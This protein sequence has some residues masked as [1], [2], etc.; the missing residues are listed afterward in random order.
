MEKRTEKALLITGLVCLAAALIWAIIVSAGRVR[1]E[2]ELTTF[3]LA[4]AYLEIR[5]LSGALGKNTDA[6]LAA[7]RNAGL[8]SVIVDSSD[9]SDG[10]TAAKK[11]GLGIIYK[12][13][14]EKGGKLS[15]LPPG[16]RVLFVN[17]QIFNKESVL[18]KG[19][20]P[21]LLEL[22]KPAGYEGVPRESILTAHT[23]KDQEL[24][25]LSFFKLRDRFLRARFERRTG[26]LYLKFKC[27]GPGL[28]ENEKL[29]AELSA[30]LR[31]AGE[32]P[33]I[34]NSNPYLLGAGQHIQALK[35]T[36]FSLALFF[37]LLAF[38]AGMRYFSGPSAR[39]LAMFLISLA[40][41]IIISALLSDTVFMIKLEQFGG[42]KYALSLPVALVLIYLGF[43]NRADFTRRGL[44]VTGGL[45]LLFAVIFAVASV[46]SGNFNMPLFPFEESLRGF[47]ENIFRAR[48]R[49]KE[50]LIGYPCLLLGLH[51]LYEERFKEFRLPAVILVSV[52][53]F[54]L[55]SVVNTFCHA[56]I[57]FLLSLLRS[58]YGA[59]LGVL[60]GAILIWLSRLLRRS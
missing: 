25:K 58:V 21:C 41:G 7:L 40:G 47:L 46:R 54:G 10:E 1:V 4:A 19:F 49:A 51:M 24:N 2:R 55:T 31:N 23:V 39:F 52:G 34:F 50:F 48:P 13:D 5:E 60:G 18:S 42:V 33:G 6:E 36:A 27:S 43:I 56:H 37:P 57:P 26:I 32:K 15:G 22:Y 28:A 17:N 44:A 38:F 53:V 20:K 59:V 35:Y 16:A 14:Y 9:R 45:T 30:L 29:V 8:T 11:N 3:D 12:A